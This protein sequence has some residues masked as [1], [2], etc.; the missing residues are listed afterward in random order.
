M[1]M[2]I[3][4]IALLTFF[5]NIAGTI[6]GFGVGTIM[7]PILLLFLPFTHT[8]L[9]VCII[10]WFHDIWKLLFFH[11][12]IDWQLFIYFG[13][14]TIIAAFIGAL[15]V[16]P[17]QSVLL[18]SLLG[19]FL[20]GSVG[21]LFCMPSFT[22]SYNWISGLIGGALSGF[23]AGIFG[24]RGAVRSM[25]LVA[26]DLHKATFIGTTGAISLLLD[27]V[28]LIAYF[29]RGL[30]LDTVLYWALFLFVPLSFLGT[31]VGQFVLG[32]IPQRHFRTVVAIFLLVV[33]IKLLL[34]PWF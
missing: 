21:A 4:L 33:G 18:S 15:L 16:T 17:A 11:K 9:L 5:S 27:S 30:Y 26:F 19:L 6:S 2:A 3:L 20:I 24:I 25:F 14:P 29:S 23:F 12:G 31:F 28:R 13:I 34:T 32:K 7:T 8:I 1:N 10:H 22:V